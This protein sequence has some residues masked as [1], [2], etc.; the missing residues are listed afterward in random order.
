MASRNY[1][2]QYDTS[3]GFSETIWRFFIIDLSVSLLSIFNYT[4]SIQLLPGIIKTTLTLNIN[5]IDVIEMSLHSYVL[6]FSI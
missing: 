6:Q 1:Y 4:F 5:G 2:P 3:L